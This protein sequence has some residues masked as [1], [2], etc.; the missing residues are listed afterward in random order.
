MLLFYINLNCL[1]RRTKKGTRSVDLDMIPVNVCINYVTQITQRKNVATG[2]GGGF[3]KQ[4]VL[5]KGQ[6]LPGTVW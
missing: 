1:D 2:K 5:F 3:S 6:S 4:S